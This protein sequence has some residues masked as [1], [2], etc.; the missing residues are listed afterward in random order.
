MVNAYSL[1]LL[2]YPLHLVQAMLLTLLED[3]GEMTSVLIWA[4]TMAGHF[5]IGQKCSI[6]GT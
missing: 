1:K 2:L 3:N 4:S 6:D 5:V